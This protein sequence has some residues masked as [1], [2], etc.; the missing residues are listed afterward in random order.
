MTADRRFLAVVDRIYEGATDANAW[1]G[2]VDDLGEYFSAPKA[3]LFTPLPGPVDG[4]FVLSKGFAEG[5]IERWA[6]HYT[7]HD[8][9]VQAGIAKGL[10]REGQA[11]IDT[12][13]VPESE[14]QRSVIYREYLSVHDIVR[15]CSGVIFE[16]QASGIMSTLFSAFRGVRDHPF[17]AA[18]RNRMHRLIPHLSR[19]LGVMYRLRDAAFQVAAS[20]GALDRIPAA[21]VLLGA[22]GEV[23]HLNQH[24]ERLIRQQDGFLWMPARVGL[25]RLRLTDDAQQS[26]LDQLIRAVIRPGRGQR[27]EHFSH[28]MCVR[29]PSGAPDYLVRLSPIGLGN[30][31]AADV[32]SVQAIAFITDPVASDRALTAEL[33]AG[34]FQLTVAE[35]RL[36][37]ELVRGEGLAAVAARIGISPNTAKSQ[38]KAVFAKTQTRN[39]AQLVKL[40]VS[41][42]K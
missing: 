30:P 34:A 37:R 7:P 4:G 41:I 42:S 36:A 38:L 19:S 22:S 6:E 39:Q 27:V 25:G 17:T 28:A 29:R 2:I 14:L 12:D 26:V 40:L 3:W 23:R 8:I 9:W 13:L 35:S 20:L 32:G 15:L 21:V 10:L 1:R 5:V 11:V 16:Q 24:A 33:L 31:Y 18:D